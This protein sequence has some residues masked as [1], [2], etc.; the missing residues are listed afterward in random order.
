MMGKRIGD[1][2]K[3]GNVP[4][5]F[6]KYGDSLEEIFGD[7][8][9]LRSLYGLKANEFSP[10]AIGVFSYL[11]KIAY[12]IKHF[13]ALNRK[14]DLNLWDRSDLIPVTELAKDALK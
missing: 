11:Q 3:E 7:L 9:D 5:Q 12:G 6:K 8:A 4:K 13:G 2:I 1:Q 10:G 14:F